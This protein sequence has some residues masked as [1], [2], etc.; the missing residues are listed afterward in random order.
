MSWYEKADDET[1]ADSFS[2]TTALSGHLV[3]CLTS[4]GFPINRRTVRSDRWEIIWDDSIVNKIAEDH[5]KYRGQLQIRP[6]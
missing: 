1:A 6:A 2:Y 4:T 3:P 5:T